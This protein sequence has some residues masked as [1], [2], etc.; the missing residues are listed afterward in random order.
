MRDDGPRDVKAATRAHLVLDNFW[1]YRL[2]VISNR[3]S[4]AIARQYSDR[5]GLSVPEW[6]VMAVLGGMPGLS[7]RD[8][9]QRTAMDKVRVS[10][11]VANLVTVGRVSR[12]TD[13]QDGRIT[14]LSLTP[15]G[16]DIYDQI[17][18]MALK[19]EEDVFSTLSA[20]DRELLDRVMAKLAHQ[21][22]RLGAFPVS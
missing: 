22:D 2:S 18:P 21:A 3:I 12:R 6:R 20:E 5:F 15:R 4:D 7:A 10:R 11:A 13:A 1:P 19:L 16:Q 8:V 14:R 9:A 17:V